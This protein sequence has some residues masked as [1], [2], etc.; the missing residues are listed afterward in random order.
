MAESPGASA[1]EAALAVIVLAAGQGTRMRSAR[2]K[3]L[4]EIAGRPML[5]YP[6]ALAEALAPERLVVVVGRD[7]EAVRE[8]FAGRAEFVEQAEPR[9][10]GHAVQVALPALQGFGGE[11][12]VLYGD[13]PLLRA[14]S[15]ARMRAVKARS[16]APLVILSSPEPLP[17]LVVRGADGR[18]ERI[19]E[20][21]DATP[22]ELASLREGNTGVYLVDLEL[23]REA[24]GELDAANQ[25]GELYLTDVVARARARGL[26]VEGIRLVDADEALGVNT[27]A[28]LARATQ[29]QHRRNAERWM[30]EGVSFVAPDHAWIDTDVTIGADSIVEPGVVI[31]GASQLGRGV[32]VKAHTVIESS[33]ID[34]DVVI[35]PTAHLRPGNHLERG[36]RIG[37]FV[38]LK[39]SHLG[40]GVKA[41]HL[42]Y[43][44]DADV[45]ARSSFGC[46]AITVNYD[47]ERKHRT[48]VGV[49]VRIGC[50]ANLIAPR[51]LEDGAHVAAGVTVTRD[52]PAGAL[53]R[54]EARQKNIE[55]WVERR[56]KARSGKSE[57]G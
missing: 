30:D 44:G 37:N 50:N 17:G 54:S 19:V 15:V 36:V 46:G 7:A 48:H 34:D 18:V 14:E 51:R 31:T 41:D 43:V 10:T 1:S 55:G 5:G 8:A 28:E 9:G 35:G 3:V 33:R 45:G 57:S 40:E 47:W 16:G 25:Q 27:R 20:Q 13:V 56:V 38:E 23:L 29:V 4:H 32:H 52:V 26:A 53:A 39:N 24:L 21:T 12:L 42:T 6:L 22:E 2:S 49:G 11:V